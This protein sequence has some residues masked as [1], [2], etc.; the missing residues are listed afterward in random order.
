MAKSYDIE[1]LDADL[2]LAN[3]MGGDYGYQL[4]NDQKSFTVEQYGAEG[5]VEK[6]YTLNIQI[7]ENK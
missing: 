3:E 1:E 5:E 6:T 2:S 7:E 4:N